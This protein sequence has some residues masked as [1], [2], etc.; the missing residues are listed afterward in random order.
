MPE[1]FTNLTQY[2]RNRLI[3]ACATA[4]L[5]AGIG[6][7]LGGNAL[8]TITLLGIAAMTPIGLAAIG[9]IIN[10]RG[11]LVNIGIEGIIVIAGLTSIWSAEYLGSPYLALLAGMATGAVLS[12]IF[13][14]IATYG[15]GSQIIAGLGMNLIGLGVVSFGLVQ[16]W[17]TPGFHM[18]GDDSLRPHRMFTPWGPISWLYFLTF[19]VA[20][21]A[22]F[23]LAW[24]RFGMHVQAS[25]NN[26]F[27][28]D[29]NG[30]DVYKV[31]IKAC[32]MGGALSGLAGGF[33]AVDYLG[34][35]TKDVSQGRGFMALACIVFSAL[36]IPLAL[37]IAFV[38]GLTEAI[39]LW[40][41]N[42]AWA[43]DFVV[44]G[45]NSFLLMIPYLSVILALAL[46]PGFERLS[47]MIG[48]NYWRGQ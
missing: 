16:I 37:G 15:R 17:G 34:G 35:V 19:I 8:L 21:L 29:A 9:E 42:A 40:V 12:F 2:G 1:Y 47:K 20:V 27:V 38:F 11:G 32:V 41:Q 43:K 13:G 46:F 24:T 33:L 10:Q 6:I 44:L 28:T 25:G 18:L 26:P 7:A 22:W 31:R 39:A 36:D 23:M 45:G 30:I 3:L 4:L 14:I 5:L 48:E